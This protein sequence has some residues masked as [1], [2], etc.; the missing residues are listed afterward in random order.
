LE[1]FE[2][3]DRTRKGLRLMAR[4]ENG[5]TT[6]GTHTLDTLQVRTDYPIFFVASDDYTLAI[7]NVELHEN[8]TF[9]GGGATFYDPGLFNFITSTPT[10]SNT[11]L[12]A[13]TEQGGSPRA[14]TVAF[15]DF[16][17]GDNDAD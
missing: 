13:I 11:L 14:V 5:A 17:V 2:E 16:S 1:P 9:I 3:I 12:G 6:G 7:T 15:N 4:S 10:V 8:A